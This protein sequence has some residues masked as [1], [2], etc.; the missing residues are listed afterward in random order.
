MGV[1]ET[2]HILLLSLPKLLQDVVTAVLARETDFVIVEPPVPSGSIAEL[3]EALRPDVIITTEPATCQPPVVIRLFE[4]NPRLKV[5][6]V[7]ASG[8]N[9]HLAELRP[10]QRALGELAP[11][12]LVGAI[13][14]AVRTPFSTIADPRRRPGG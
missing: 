5:F 9:V 1:G 11:R 6:C 13:R 4:L 3:T 10:R 7:A 12:D 14:G 2:I 8:S